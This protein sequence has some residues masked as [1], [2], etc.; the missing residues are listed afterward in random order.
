MLIYVKKEKKSFSSERRTDE[1]S[2][3]NYS[4]EPHKNFQKNF[5]LENS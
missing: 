1:R 2:T 5:Q 4:L 3:Q